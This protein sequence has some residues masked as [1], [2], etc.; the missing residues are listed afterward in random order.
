L[1]STPFAPS[2]DASSSSGEEIAR[3]PALGEKVA[4]QHEKR[5][6]GE[7]VVAQ[8]LVSGVRDERAHHRDVALHHV[9]ADDG[10]GAERHGDMHAGEHHHQHDGEEQEHFP[11]AEHGSTLEQAV[12]V[13]GR[14][15]SAAAAQRRSGR[16]G[17][18]SSAG[19]DWR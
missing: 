1:I 12:A 8:R 10:A 18:T 17:R 16:S 2:I 4:H 6:D 15:R 3:R 9:D 5:Y 19:P 7:H 11:G 14:R 13:S